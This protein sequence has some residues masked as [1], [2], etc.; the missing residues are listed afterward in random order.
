M[1]G[2]TPLLPQRS[3]GAAAA[4]PDY[5]VIIIGAGLSGLSLACHLVQSPW[6]N[7]SILLVD[8]V[9]AARDDRT[10]CYWSNAPTMFDGAVSRTWDRLRVAGAGFERTLDLGDYRY[11]MIRGAGFHCHARAVLAAHDN[12]TLAQGV[13]ER[14]EDGPAGARVRVDGRT[15]SATWV[16]DSRFL[17]SEMGSDDARYHTLK[18]HFKG[19]E[20]E[21]PEPAFDPG[22][23]TLFDFRT[24]QAGEV[25]FFYVLPITDRRALVEY[26]LF[27]PRVLPRRGYEDALR[28]YLCYA[29]GVTGFRVLREEGGVIP[30]TDRPFPRRAGEH[31]MNI[32]TRGGRVKPSTGYAFMRVQQDSAAIVASLVRRGHP[33]DV[34]AD[35]RRY[36]LYD[37]I[38]LDI[39]CRRG[40]EIAPIFT[41]MFA[42]NRI[43]RV[44]RFLDEIGSARENLL[45][46]A[47]LPPRLFLESIGRAVA[48]IP[49]AP[50]P[51]GSVARR[52]SRV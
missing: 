15:V 18:L 29:S 34:P 31:V 52:S 49:A 45:L 42:H 20:I 39:M 4:R 41:A 16:F 30:A 51:G 6:R 1:Y 7:R 33:F 46:I 5:D 24:P 11:K 48:G 2:R 43:E 8:K 28:H 37:S 14:I 35:S 32:G 21:T 23:P 36:R 27:A 25:R 10:W 17:P 19:W 26:T 40:G 3:T 38:L 22:M 50:G 13:V 44:L 12:V 47:T 9:A